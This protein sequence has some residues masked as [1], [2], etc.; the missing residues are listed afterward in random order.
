MSIENDIRD[1]GILNL[2]ESARY[3][4]M[5]TKAARQL[6]LAGEL[7]GARK[8]GNNHWQIPRGSCD[9]WIHEDFNLGP[10]MEQFVRIAS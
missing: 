8:K 10:E 1:R 4:G 3:L 2:A 6:A 7:R 9:Y 5:S